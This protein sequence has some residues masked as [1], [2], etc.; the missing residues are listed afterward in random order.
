MC[1]SIPSPPVMSQSVPFAS[2]QHP[3]VSGMA[4]NPAPISFVPFH[5]A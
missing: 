5:S 4:E 3:A 1:P 2:H